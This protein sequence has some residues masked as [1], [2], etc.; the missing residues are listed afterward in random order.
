MKRMKSFIVKAS[1]VVVSLASFGAHAGLGSSA[2]IKT[3]NF[4]SPISS[5]IHVKNVSGSIFSSE[6]ELQVQESSIDIVA[7]GSLQCLNSKF[8][9]YTKNSSKI[10]F[11]ALYENGDDGNT[12]HQAPHK[13]TT[14][15]RKWGKGKWSTKTVT[16]NSQIFTVPLNKLEST[17]P[18]KG[19]RVLLEMEKKLQAHLQNGGKE[20]DFYKND[21]EIVLQRPISL[22]ASCEGN[23]GGNQTYGNKHASFGTSYLTTAYAIHDHTIKILYKGDSNLTN[24]GIISVK[25][26]GNEQNQLNNILP[27]KLDKATFLPNMPHH[28]GQCIPNKNPSLRMNFQMSGSKMGEIDVRVVGTSNFGQQETYFETTGIIKSSGNDHLDFEFPLKELLSQYKYSYMAV[29]GNKTYKHNM[30][31]QARYKDFAVGSTWSEYK[32]YDAAVFKH[33][34]TPQ[35]AVKL[36]GNGKKLG[37]QGANKPARAKPARLKTKP[38]RLNP[39]LNKAPA[40]QPLGKMSPKPAPKF[41]DV[42]APKLT[43]KP[44]RL[45]KK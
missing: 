4:S 10:Y 9:K 37:Y 26:A 6:V 5:V 32:S 24:K 27:F 43:P 34:C 36:G 23:I 12:V 11:G 8:V 25:A 29:A 39:S 35:V 21:Q 45:N 40:A 42:Q 17:H 3:I 2:H 13:I 1:I 44:L 19:V 16:Y 15:Q 28:I 14:K 20:I 38:A 7:N 30:N 33:R 41:L 18:F 31:I 22:I